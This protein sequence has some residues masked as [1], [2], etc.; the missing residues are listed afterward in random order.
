[1][2]NIDKKLMDRYFNATAL[3]I[4]DDLREIYPEDKITTEDF[5]RILIEDILGHKCKAVDLISIPGIYE[6]LSEHFNNEVIE[7]WESE[8]RT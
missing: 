1:M 2:R 8:Q 4:E 6:I 7:L 5:D 3:Q